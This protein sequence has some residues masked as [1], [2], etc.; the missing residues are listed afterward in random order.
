M[1]QFINKFKIKYTDM[2]S[3]TIKDTLTF[4]FARNIGN[5]N[6]GSDDDNF[7]NFSRKLLFYQIGK[8]FYSLEITDI[9]YTY[10]MGKTS[11][12]KKD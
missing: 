10:V 3:L 1:Q 7:D 11:S 6:A 5:S 4:L 9:L 12:L 2:K 8:Y